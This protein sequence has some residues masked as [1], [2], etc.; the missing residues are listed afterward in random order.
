MWSLQFLE[1]F[2]V[3]AQKEEKPKFV[4]HLA[5]NR[6]DRRGV[7]LIADTFILPGRPFSFAPRQAALP[8]DCVFE[9]SASHAVIEAENQV[10][11]LPHLLPP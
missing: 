4:D 6:S 9:T 3:I 7:G 1:T 8:G 10:Q 2:W 11:E 5:R